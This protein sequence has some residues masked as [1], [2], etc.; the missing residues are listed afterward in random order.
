MRYLPFLFTFFF[1]LSCS[2]KKESNSNFYDKT[3]NFL[4]ENP[5]GEIVEFPE[6]YGGLAEKIPD[7]KDQKLKLVENLKTKGF[8][9]IKW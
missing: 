8:K 2:K 3:L 6:I 7:D 4:I 1:F 5:D 9:V